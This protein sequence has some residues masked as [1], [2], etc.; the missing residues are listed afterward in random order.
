MT[1]TLETMSEGGTY[2]GLEHH[3]TKSMLERSSTAEIE[4]RMGR[5]LSSAPAQLKQILYIPDHNNNVTH[6][7]LYNVAASY[8]KTVGEWPVGSSRFKTSLSLM[9]K[10]VGDGR[11]AE[12]TYLVDFFQGLPV[13][14]TV[15]KRTLGHQNAEATLYV[16]N[17]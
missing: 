5:K 9:Q 13:T 1:F 6:L 3:A 7:P 8:N 17:I 12:V 10:P 4:T 14:A 11:D 2:S 15:S 16:R